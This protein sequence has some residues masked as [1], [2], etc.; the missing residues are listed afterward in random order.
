[1]DTSVP[2]LCATGGIAAGFFSDLFHA[3]ALTCSTMLIIAAPMVRFKII[4]VV[5]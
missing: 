2:V 1:M 3:Q 5:C 4:S